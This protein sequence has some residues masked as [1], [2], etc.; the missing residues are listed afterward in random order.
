MAWH[1]FLLSKYSIVKDE[2]GWI[3][4]CA[5]CF[6][7]SQDRDVRLS[8][9]LSYALRHGANRMGLQMGS[10]KGKL[11]F[12]ERKTLHMPYLKF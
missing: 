1:D 8:K 6:F 2:Y 7:F 12:T 4:L 11:F 9:S 10:G 3:F 5:C